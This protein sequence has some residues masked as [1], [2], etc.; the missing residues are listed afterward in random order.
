MNFTNQTTCIL[1]GTHLDIAQ[2]MLDYDYL[3]GRSPSI[4]AIMSSGSEGRNYKVFYGDKEIIIP[5]ISTWE[6]VRQ[7][8]S[9][10]ILINLASFRSATAV[11][12]EAIDSGLFDAIFTIAEG[13]PERETRELIAYQQ[14]T[15]IKTNHT[16]QLF[17]PAIVWGL[18]AW[19]IRV[20]N[21]GG[22]LE[23][24]IKAQLYRPWSVAIVSKSW[25]MMN[26]LMHIASRYA[27]GVHTALQIGGDRYPMTTFSDI[28][29]MYQANDQIKTIVMLGEV[30]NEN[31][32]D[33]ADMIRDGRIIK[34]VV[35]RCCGTSADQL[36]SEIQ[37]GHAGAKAN[38][39][40]ETAKFKNDNLRNAGA[41]VP[42]SFDD[43]GTLLATL[44]PE[45]KT[46]TSSPDIQSKVDTITHRQPTLFS[47][48]I[49]DE[50]GEE[51]LYDNIPVSDF[52]TSQSI[53][54]VIGHLWLKKE[55][56]DR[57]S[58]FITTA[59]ILLA[60][61]GPAV[62][63]AV[64][65][66]ITARAGKDLVT[67]LIAGLATIWPRFG[68]AITDAAKYFWQARCD[69]QS[70]SDFVESMK[71]QG[72]IIPGIG[73]KIKSI[74]NPDR[75][76]ELLRTCRDKAPQRETLDFALAVEELTT[77]KKANLILNVDGHIAA[78]LIDMMIA[79]EMSDDEIGMY[80]DGDLCNGLFIA[81]RMIGF[82]GHYLDEQRLQEGLFRMPEQH[83]LYGDN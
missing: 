30:W 69:G 40:R 35:A 66:K 43:F 6:Q 82:I 5:R 77:Q 34:P 21:T 16:T 14:E 78:M 9:A 83:I 11:N 42:E 4:S 41:H 57:A 65:T 51:L 28:I 12:R 46:M 63:G 62:S 26:E 55:L 22:S 8:P 59:L 7:F 54:K 25:G 48:T 50:R 61:H 45:R 76:C 32:N 52:V 56:P 10:T 71:R 73:H 19:V 47:S 3:C 29:Q 13:I 60:D 27:D 23:N 20:G 39:E 64:N 49:S 33:I 80:I 67:S 36:S 18:I 2:R 53:A 37:F 1:Y 72:I 15:Q 81:A 70:A 74:Y 31:E 17:W 75:R 58:E 68:W 38:A 79:L 44:Y 24:I